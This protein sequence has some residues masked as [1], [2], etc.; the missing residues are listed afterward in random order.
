MSIISSLVIYVTNICSVFELIVIL[1]D[2]GWKWSNRNGKT[3][4]VPMNDDDNFNW[5]CKEF[6]E[7]ELSHLV[8]EKEKNGEVI[9]IRLF[10]QYGETG[11]TLLAHNSA[12]YSFLFDCNRKTLTGK[13]D[14]GSTNVNWY[15]ERIV[16]TLKK[17]KV[18]I[19]SIQY[20]E[21]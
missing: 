15:M 11:I 3:E 16:W 5:S 1:N 4:F 10:Y 13:H 17:Q 14:I 7:E 8:N 21:Y 18:E 12:Q 20:Q 19:Q 9:G 6:S 2:I